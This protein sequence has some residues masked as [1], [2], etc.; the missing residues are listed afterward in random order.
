MN[1]NCFQNPFA[2]GEIYLQEKK[3]GFIV[4][5]GVPSGLK[6]YRYGFTLVTPER[7]WLFGADTERER[8]EW[9]DILNAVINTPEQPHD[10][11]VNYR[12]QMKNSY[13]YRKM[14]SSNT[15]STKSNQ[16]SNSLSSLNIGDRS[17]NSSFTSS[18]S[19]V[20]KKGKNF[21]SIS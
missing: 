8:D 6:E 14:R 9:I 11:S 5:I 15:L 7:K 1:L 18:N 20:Q 3:E 21:F 12:Y 17:S 19:S 10:Y 13:S 16:T 2:K 4:I